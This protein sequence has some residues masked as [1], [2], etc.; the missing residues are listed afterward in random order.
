MA[1]WKRWL[2]AVPLPRPEPVLEHMQAVLAALQPWSTGRSMPNFLVSDDPADMPRLWAPQ[3]YAR[4]QELAQRYDPHS[5]LTVG[6]TVVR[7][8]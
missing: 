1:A 4:L 5:L 8:T 7:S 6:T 2:G 3:T